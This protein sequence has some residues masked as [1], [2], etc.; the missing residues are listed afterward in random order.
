[1]MHRATQGSPRELYSLS[2]DLGGGFILP[3]PGEVE[4]ILLVV[5]M[6]LS[7]I[8]I[9][10]K[11]HCSVCVC[12]CGRGGGARDVSSLSLW[13]IYS[14]LYIL[15]PIIKRSERNFSE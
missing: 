7:W 3:L 9:N 5:I 11:K 12:V 2:G 15:V 13:I 10:L 1:M 6:F 4:K 8:A 14:D